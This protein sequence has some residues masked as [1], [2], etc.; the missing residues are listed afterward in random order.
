M[1]GGALSISA[2]IGTFVAFNN[3]SSSS[4]SWGSLALLLVALALFPVG[5]A[6]LLYQGENGRL[7]LR[8]QARRKARRAAKHPESSEPMAAESGSKKK[9]RLFRIGAFLLL[10]GAVLLTVAYLLSGFALF[11]LGLPGFILALSGLIALVVSL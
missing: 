5:I 8:R 6:L 2:L 9:G 11:F 1:I 7:R 10:V 3:D 4:S